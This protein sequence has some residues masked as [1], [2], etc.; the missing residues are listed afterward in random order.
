VQLKIHMLHINQNVEILQVKPLFLRQLVALAS[1]SR[2]LSSSSINASNI[3]IIV[4]SEA[5][6]ILIGL[7]ALLNF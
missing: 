7:S 3:V 1:F 6:H 5:M 4:L 2:Y